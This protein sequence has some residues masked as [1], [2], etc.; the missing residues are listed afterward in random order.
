MSGRAA[1]I[2]HILGGRSMT[3]TALGFLLGVWGVHQFP[4]LPLIG[5]VWLLPVLMAVL[6]WPAVPRVVTAAGCGF[7]WTLFL[8]HQALAPSLNPEWE[9]RDL[10][11]RG[12]VASIPE[13]QGRATRF[14]FE[15][16]D[17]DPAN[18]N[19]VSVLPMRVR[20][21]WYGEV[22]E[23][24]Y[25][26][27]WE[28]AVRLK[29]PWGFSNPGGF[30]YESWLFRNGIRATGY[31]RAG[32]ESAPVGRSVVPWSP[33]GLRQSLALRL[34]AALAEDPNRG[35]IMALAIGLR[36]GIPD[37]VWEVLLRTGTNHL[38]AISGLHIG[39]V[40]GFCFWLARRSWR[41]S[42]WLCA[43]LPAPRAGAWAALLGGSAYALLAGFSLPTQRALIMLAVAMAAVILDRPVRAVPT[44]ALALLL[45]LIR[46]PFAILSP[47]LWLSFGAV[48]VILYSALGA[49]TGQ[50]RLR[51]WGWVQWAVAMGTL[52][53]TLVLFQRAALVAPVANLIAVPWVGLLIVPLVLAGTLLL[54]PVPVVGV[55]LLNAASTL[56]EPLW[57]ILGLL[58]DFPL[59]QWQ[60]APPVWTFL[61]MLIGV[62]WLLAPRG[63]PA[64]WLGLVFVAPAL[65]VVSSVPPQG[66]FR[67]SVLDVGQGSAAVVETHGHVLVVDAGARY[68]DRF[69]AGEAVIAPFLVSRGHRAMDLLILSHGDGDH[70]GGAAG[71]LTRIPAGDVLASQPEALPEIRARRCRAGMEWVWDGVTF[72]VL[73]PP[74]RWSGS[75]NDVSCVLRI[76]A[77]GGAVLLPGDIEARAE[78]RLVAAEGSRLRSD[79][80]VVPHHGSATSSTREL[81]A[82]VAPRIAIVSAGYRN[83][84]GF[85]K[86]VIVARYAERGV[87]FY[88]TANRG[89][90]TVSVD[91]RAGV[92]VTPGHR[93]R[94]LRFW[95]GR[96]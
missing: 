53:L 40:A 59:A 88:D 91:P 61:P 12:T 4:V 7:L 78:R 73:H 36:T 11:V 47:G 50:R 38:L 45:V 81:L 42:A 76:S 9:G 49:A 35:V 8:A 39:L 51:A 10:N 54:V 85:P 6:L 94:D 64:R 66:G 19:A 96:P 95:T 82:A 89:A 20:L 30:D 37:P 60:G 29:R 55:W 5:L 56:L 13:H 80:L 22:P 93:G 68:S 32:T 28:L 58:G 84:F 31:V 79:V 67:L 75:D 3:P 86:P 46:D 26:Q 63:W 62:I 43:R 57:W 90:I 16:R 69:N 41:G 27:T 92:Q 70:T 34:G 77:P 71:L 72:D 14:L 52:P 87:T 48:A 25:G 33:G 18:S 44:L 23:L 24:R 74:E 83:R 2:M 17:L 21:A 15:V 65:W 1:S